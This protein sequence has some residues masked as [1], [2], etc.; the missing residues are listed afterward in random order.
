MESR[1]S[2]RRRVLLNAWNSLTSPEHCSYQPDN[3]END[4]DNQRYMDKSA[5]TP[6][7][8]PSV[9]VVVDLELELFTSRNPCE[10]K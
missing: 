5:Q 3:Y 2:S 6:D 7:K 8:H 1:G 9:L 10:L 4:G